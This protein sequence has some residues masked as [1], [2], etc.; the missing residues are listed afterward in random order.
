[1]GVVEQQLL[2]PGHVAGPRDAERIAEQ[3]AGVARA[4]LGQQPL[5]RSID[6][7]ELE[8]QCGLRRVAVERERPVGVVVGPDQLRLQPVDPADEAAEQRT[9]AAAEVVALER[10]LVDPLEQH[11]EPLARSEHRLERVDRRPRP[12]QHQRRQLHRREHEQLL[13]GL[14]QGDLEPGAQR[15][16]ARPRRDD[17]EDPLRSGPGAD[18]PPE[19]GF[20]DARL[21]GPS[22]TDHQQPSA[23]VR[24]GLTLSRRQ[25]VHHRV[26]RGPHGYDLL[27][28]SLPINLR[29]HAV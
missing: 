4:G 29:A 25:L 1:M 15:V 3:T 5:V 7:G 2:D 13:V 9:R 16:G 18:Q 6:L 24:D 28:T 11:G 12:P 19:P 22:A 26:I 14:H 23:P 27:S 17:H 20:D 21:A 8:R 10:E